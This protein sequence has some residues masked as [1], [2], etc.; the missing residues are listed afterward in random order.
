[1]IRRRPAMT[2]RK[3]ALYCF[4][5]LALMR[6]SCVQAGVWGVDPTIAITGDYST[7][8]ALIFDPPPGTAAAHGAVLLDAPTSYNGDGLVVS[9]IPSFRVSDSPGYSSLA[10]DYEHLS[11]KSEFDSERNVFTAT[12]TVNQDSSLYQTYLTDGSTGVKR[13]TLAGDVAWQRSLTELLNFGTEINWTQVKYGQALGVGTLTDFRD[14]TIVPTLTW[15]SS[16]RNKVTL[17]ASVSRYDSLG[18][19]TESRSANLQAGFVRQLSEIWSIEGDFG[20]SRALNN[21]AF[22]AEE[23]VDTPAGLAIELVPISEESSQN[24]TVYAATLSR[25]GV[26]LTCSLTASRQLVPSGFAYLSQQTS[27]ELNLNYT[28]SERWTLGFD[29]RYLRAQDPQLRG[30]VTERT[31]ISIVGSAIYHLSEHWNASLNVSRVTERFQPPGADLS[32]NEIVITF[33]RQFD[34]LKFQ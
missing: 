31:P 16:E 3:R 11:V 9:I 23:I 18:A 20:Y 5:W 27:V 15:N 19:S 4:G 28:A 12:A 29:A 22:D 33:S 2:W 1:M 26:L 25:K 34:H 7:N 24:G 21:I 17:S 13:D 6:T 32:S 14:T 30:G 10:S 8:P